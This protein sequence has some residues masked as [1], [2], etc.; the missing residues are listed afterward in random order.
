MPRM[1]E[2]V[3]RLRAVNAALEESEG[4]LDDDLEAAFGEVRLEYHEKVEGYLAVAREA[5]ALAEIEKEREQRAASRRKRWERR[6]EWLTSQVQAA[7]E[8]AGDDRF[9]GE[10][11]EAWLQKSGTP[12]VEYD[13]SLGELPPDYRR[14]K[15]EPDLKAV[16][17]ALKEGRAIPGCFTVEPPKRYLRFK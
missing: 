9:S 2:I 10:L 15:V 13:P 3:C 1:P 6:A 14:V 12:K 17:L 7:M 5:Q 11:H 8:A 16:Q 4:E